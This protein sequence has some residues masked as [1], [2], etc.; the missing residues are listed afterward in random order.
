MSRPSELA[1]PGGL[2]VPLSA[3]LVAVLE[4]ATP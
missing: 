2:M 1:L 4:A 3:E